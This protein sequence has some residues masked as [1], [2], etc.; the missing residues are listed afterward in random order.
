[1]AKTKFKI[2]GKIGRQRQRIRN[3]ELQKT[4]DNKPPR[5]IRR[6]L[7]KQAIRESKR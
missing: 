7:T 3:R 5:R 2:K 4:T 6:L 1:M